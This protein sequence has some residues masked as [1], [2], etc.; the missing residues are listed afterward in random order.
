MDGVNDDD[1]G[2]NLK[3]A[4]EGRKVSE[5]SGTMKKG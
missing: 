2:E 4:N 1:D 3:R 5:K